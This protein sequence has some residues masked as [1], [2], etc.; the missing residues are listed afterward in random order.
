MFHPESNNKSVEIAY[1]TDNG[2]L[3]NYSIF[4]LQLHFQVIISQN[5]RSSL[6]DLYKLSSGKPMVHV[7]SHPRLKTKVRDFPYCCATI[8]EGLVHAS[9]LC[10]VGMQWNQTAFRQDELEMMIGVI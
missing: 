5:R 8:Q 3:G 1:D 2:K 7:I 6:N 4:V 10:D 9:H